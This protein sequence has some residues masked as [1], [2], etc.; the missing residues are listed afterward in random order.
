VSAPLPRSPRAHDVYLTPGGLY[1]SAAPCVMSTLLGSCVAVTLWCP[2]G[3]VGAM[4][5]YLLPR[6]HGRQERSARHGDSAMAMLL[7][8]MESFACARD[9]IQARIFG[10]AAV[11][12]G[13]GTSA[14]AL[15]E[16][17]VAAAWQFLRAHKIRIVEE[18]VGGNTAR[19][20]SFDV[21]NGQVHVSTLGGA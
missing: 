1:A 18:H 6:H 4:N 10:G 14:A 9:R 12:A 15:G 21:E 7:A 20:I 13:Q 16:Q 11:L 2:D 5:H 3:S 19:R 8:R 17:N